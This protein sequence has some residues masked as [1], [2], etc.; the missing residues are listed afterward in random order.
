MSINKVTK[1]LKKLEAS[2]D[3]KKGVE[4]AEAQN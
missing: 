4:Y 2:D 3:S 1:L